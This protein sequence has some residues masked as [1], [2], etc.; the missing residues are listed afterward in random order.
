MQLYNN[1]NNLIKKWTGELKRYFSKKDIKVANRHM[2]RCSTSL[3][4]RE[5]TNTNHTKIPLHT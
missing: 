5:I 1:N 4:V 2:I 3:I